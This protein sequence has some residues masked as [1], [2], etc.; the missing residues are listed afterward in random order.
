M[1][2]PAASHHCP[3]RRTST[4]I[5][6]SEN[7]SVRVAPGCHRLA[8]GV[9][10]ESGDVGD[11]HILAHCE[12]VPNLIANRGCG[13]RPALEV[14]VNRVQLLVALDQC[15]VR[16]APGHVGGE[17]PVQDLGVMPVVS[18]LQARRE[19][20]DGGLGVRGT[21]AETWSPGQRQSPGLWI[22]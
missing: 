15:S 3:S 10:H 13:A 7:G 6:S 17:L 4:Y 1:F 19:L 11:D 12:H 5:A 18:G 21:G 9:E 20:L 2:W 14:G 22:S 16:A 8:V